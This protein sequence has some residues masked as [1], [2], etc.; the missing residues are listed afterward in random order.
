MT[1]IVVGRSIEAPA[2]V[3]FRAVSDV[4]NLPATVYGD[5]GISLFPATI[6][7]GGTVVDAGGMVYNFGPGE[8][9]F[10]FVA[11]GS[12]RLDVTAPAG[13]SA[14]SVVPTVLLQALPG[15]PYAINEQ[16]SRGQ[17]FAVVISNRGAEGAVVADTIRLE[18]VPAR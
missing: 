15:A 2:E 6:I 3:V 12:Y 13:Y 11:P 4:A 16:G 14:P 8:Y 7:S 10:P 5:D 1:R 17:P 9:R 18:P